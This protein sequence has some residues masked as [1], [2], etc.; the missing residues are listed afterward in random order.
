MGWA[1]L[2][3]AGEGSYPFT[4]LIG[5]ELDAFAIVG[6]RPVVPWH[7]LPAAIAVTATV[8][9]ACRSMGESGEQR[10]LEPLRSKS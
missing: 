10:G 2:S 5:Q 8:G 4:S 1:A 3:R 7:Q 6:P 9:M